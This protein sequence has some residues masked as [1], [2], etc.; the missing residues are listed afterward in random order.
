[1]EPDYYRQFTPDLDIPL[2]P[3]K[4]YVLCTDLSYPLTTLECFWTWVEKVYR[5]TL[6]RL[7]Q[8]EKNPN[9]DDEDPTNHRFSTVFRKHDNGNIWATEWFKPHL[10][11]TC[12]K[13]I[14]LNCL[15]GRVLVRIST[16]EAIGWVRYE[17]FDYKKMIEQLRELTKLG[18]TYG[19]WP[20]TPT[21]SAHEAVDTADYVCYYHFRGA[22]M[23]A[24]YYEKSTSLKEAQE[25][26]TYV[27]GIGPFISW[28]TTLDVHISFDA[29]HYIEDKKIDHAITGPGSER[30]LYCLGYND[31]ELPTLKQVHATQDNYLPSDMP[32]LELYDVEHALCEWWVWY[33]YEMKR[34]G[35]A[36]RFP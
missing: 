16:V 26:L 8:R 35:F 23:L 32:R 18:P 24:D 34:R 15:M 19:S 5:V 25:L 6:W 10:D 14:M 28:Q 7:E 3:S 31:A 12:F 1:M 11:E 33:S 20:V 4:Q 2:H 13:T 36:I 30:A 27:H 21:P 22:L 17:D 9:F 29:F